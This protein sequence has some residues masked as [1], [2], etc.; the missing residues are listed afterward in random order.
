MFSKGDGEMKKIAGF[1]RK[2]RVPWAKYRDRVHE[3][4]KTLR[5]EVTPPDV[6]RDAK[7]PHSAYHTYFEWNDRTAGARYRLDQARHLLANLKVIY[8]DE[9][10]NE[11][12]VREYVRLVHES[13]A[14]HE[15]RAGYFPRQKAMTNPQLEIQCVERAIQ[16]L[17]SWMNRWRGFKRI[18]SYYVGVQTTLANLRRLKA[19]AVRQA[20]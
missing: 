19:R 11:V 7:N 2:A 13:P 3:L 8:H 4:A 16:E 15:L 12:K 20:K 9:L 5:R 17:E 1:K 10:G 6:L 18:E 14:T